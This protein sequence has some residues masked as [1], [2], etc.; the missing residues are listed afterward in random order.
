MSGKLI[1]LGILA[2]GIVLFILNIRQS[3]QIEQIAKI[4]TYIPQNLYCTG[5][6][7]EE[8]VENKNMIMFSF[9]EN[10]WITDATLGNTAEVNMIRYVGNENFFSPELQNMYVQDSNSCVIDVKTAEEI[11]G[12]SNV[13]SKNVLI[14]GQNY[15][16]K[17]VVNTPEK[18]ILIQMKEYE[19]VK[20]D[21]IRTDNDNL[22]E[23]LLSAGV[24]CEKL[25]FELLDFI[26][27]IL[28]SVVP[29]A[30]I[31]R[32][33]QKEHAV[34]IIVIIIYV[35]WLIRTGY[36]YIPESIVI[37]KLSEFELWKETMLQMLEDI[38][39]IV[40]YGN[41]FLK[42]LIYNFLSLICVIIGTEVFETDEDQRCGSPCGDYENKYPLL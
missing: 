32:A 31:M 20:I 2:V 18:T 21:E 5:Q 37:H 24:V 15:R 28:L 23:L 35:V 10:I 11:Y 34:K 1:R 41:H 39:K 7:A 29:M 12:S 36:L 40:L 22:E 6:S 19:E 4:Y 27:K 17:Q 16:I 8:F 25:N 13:V 38:G 42:F 3:T 30:V 33:F 26:T 14:D 9:A